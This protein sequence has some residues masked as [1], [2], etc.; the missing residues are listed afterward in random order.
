ML[1]GKKTEVR[2]CATNGIW[3]W[4]VK[5]VAGWWKCKRC[6][7]S[8]RCTIEP[9]TNRSI[10]QIRSNIEDGTYKKKWRRRGRPG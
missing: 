1:K 4:W 2:D 9:P 8:V 6:N 7:Q 5:G 10:A 3:H